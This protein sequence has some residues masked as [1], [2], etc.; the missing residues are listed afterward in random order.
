MS[1]VIICPACGTRYE[2]AAVIPPEGRKVR[3]SKCSHVWQATAVIEVATPPVAAT[4]RAPVMAPR[5]QPTQPRPAPAEPRSAPAAANAP[6]GGFTGFSQKQPDR[7]APSGNPPP[8]A[9]TDAS[10]DVQ[11]EFQ[12]DFEGGHAAGG[13]GVWSEAQV[14][15]A[16][17]EPSQDLGSYKAG[18]LIDSAT[19]QAQANIAIGGERRK[20]KVSPV[21]AI[22]WGV[23]ALLLV[24]LA[25]ILALAP[26]AVVSALPGATRLYAILGRPVN[27]RGLAVQDVHYAWTD[28]GGGLVL[29]VE[30]NIV[31]LTSGNVDVPPVVIALED[32]SGKQIS[33]FTTKV[34]PLAAGA[35]TPFTVQ[36]PSPPDT[37]RSLKVR[38]AKAS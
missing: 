14:P 25:A 20:S 21:V 36:I 18:A 13:P 16:T 34:A 23:L 38:F 4:P 33:E 24:I 30:G 28:V 26:K 29:K 35:R 27:L 12:A 1:T 32:A 5:P 15:A 6:M 2:I 11:D 19:D 31:N 37:V 7:G 10:F 8:G 3:C 9:G 22:G 17:P